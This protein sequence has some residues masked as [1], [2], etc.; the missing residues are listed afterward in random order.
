MS[1]KSTFLKAVGLCVYFAHLGIGIPAS[2]G[3]IPFYEH[4]SIA[5]NRKDDLSNGYSHFMT[6]IMNLKKVVKNA[7]TSRS[8]FA[9]FDELFSGTNLEDAQE[10]CTTSILGLSKF[11]NSLFFISTHIQEL[12]NVTNEHISTYHIGCKVVDQ[13]PSFTYKLE[14]GWSNI[15]VGRILFEQQGLN[16]LL[17]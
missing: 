12:K 17:K 11:K 9:I 13:K 4:F 10:I 3:E 1:G 5:I 7:S 8:C 15:K 16:K 2:Y 14:K 6:E